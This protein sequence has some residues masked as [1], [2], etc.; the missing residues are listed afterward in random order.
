ME[1]GAEN[2]RDTSELVRMLGGKEVKDRGRWEVSQ[3]MVLTR[4][5]ADVSSHLPY[6]NF[7][8]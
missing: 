6:L 7:V 4:I 3:F 5:H 1:L 2:E 8:V